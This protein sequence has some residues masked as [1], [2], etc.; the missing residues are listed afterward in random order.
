MLRMAMIP[1]GD[2]SSDDD[3]DDAAADDDCCLPPKARS[4][5]RDR[6]LEEA[7]SS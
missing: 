5:W 3:D 6:S 2:D 1:K 4:R 7:M